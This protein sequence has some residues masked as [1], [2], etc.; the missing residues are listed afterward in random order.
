LE[1]EVEKAE[2]HYLDADGRCCAQAPGMAVFDIA[3][4]FAMIR[5]GRLISVMGALEVSERGDL[6]N[7]ALKKCYPT[8][9]T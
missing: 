4:S 2:W 6:A 7:W 5:S 3:T 1:D 8:C 9:K